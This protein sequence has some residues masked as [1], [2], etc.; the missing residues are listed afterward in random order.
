MNFE[1]WRE[2]ICDKV[3]H[4]KTLVFPESSDKNFEIAIEKLPMW[5]REECPDT[6]SNL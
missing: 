4:N 5:L 3:N 6:S 1:K 2:C